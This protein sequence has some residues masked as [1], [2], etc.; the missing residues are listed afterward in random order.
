ML[1]RLSRPQETAIPPAPSW[2]NPAQKRAFSD[3]V[4]LELGWK[5]Y[6]TGSEVEAFGDMVCQ[7]SRLAGLRRLM[8]AAIR[9]KDAALVVSLNGQINVTLSAAQKLAD[10]LDLHQREKAAMERDV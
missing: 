7:R 6:V 4:A 10:R 5:N 8:R 1:K 2:M 3:L 9:R